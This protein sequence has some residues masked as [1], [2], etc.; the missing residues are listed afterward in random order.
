MSAGRDEFRSAREGLQEEEAA[1]AAAPEVG[2]VGEVRI[3]SSSTRRLLVGV[4]AIQ[5]QGGNPEIQMC[6]C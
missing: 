6:L 5:K 3:S 4:P 1:E 2:M